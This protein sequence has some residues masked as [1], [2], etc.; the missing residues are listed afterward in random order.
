LFSSPFSGI[1][2]HQERK[3]VHPEGL[4]CDKTGIFMKHQK[5]LT[6]ILKQSNNV[7]RNFYCQERADTDK[8][9]HLHLIYNNRSV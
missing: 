4:F 2:R 9:N 5:G 8:L 6:V 7:P 1:E 3:D